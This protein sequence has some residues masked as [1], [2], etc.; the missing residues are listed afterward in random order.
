MRN[1]KMML[2]II[3][4]IMMTHDE[5][6][7]KWDW[8][9]HGSAQKSVASKIENELLPEEPD[10][11]VQVRKVDKISQFTWNCA[12]HFI[13]IDVPATMSQEWEFAG[14]CNAGRLRGSPT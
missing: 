3:V 11:G 8:C 6:S 13:V 7:R 9:L 1:T 12:R 4:N 14:G 2:M 10:M 5:F